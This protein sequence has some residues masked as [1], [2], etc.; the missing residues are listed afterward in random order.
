MAAEMPVVDATSDIGSSHDDA[1]GTATAT[2]SSPD[3]YVRY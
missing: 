1:A 3:D 2:S